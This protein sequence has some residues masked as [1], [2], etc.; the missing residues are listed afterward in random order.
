LSGRKKTILLLLIILISQKVSHAQVTSL[1]I[2]P[3]DPKPG[4]NVQITIQSTPRNKVDLILSFKGNLNVSNNEFIYTMENLEIPHNITVFQVEAEN[5][6]LLRLAVIVNEV[7]VTQTIQGTKGY[8]TISRNNILPGKYWVQISGIPSVG[9][10]KV[11]FNVTAHTSVITDNQG[12]YISSY[13]ITGFPSGEFI[14][15]ADS[16][17]KKVILKNRKYILPKSYNI[18]IE[19]FSIPEKFIQGKELELTYKITNLGEDVSGF[20][21]QFSVEN[22]ILDQEEINDIKVNETIL[23]NVLWTPKSSGLKEIQ[24]I[25]DPTNLIVETEEL[26]NISKQMIKVE[27]KKNLI[28]YLI[29]LL[30]IAIFVYFFSRF[31]SKNT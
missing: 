23:Y 13:D 26:D 3:N 11:K 17:T 9:F 21:V 25:V 16:M 22:E 27:E 31:L 6:G 19:P 30:P 15:K 1:E 2:I 14:V 18:V 8:A 29:V 7:P 28:T 10:D 12:E 4:D 5:V 20:L 24:A